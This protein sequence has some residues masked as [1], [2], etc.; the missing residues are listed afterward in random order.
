GDAKQFENLRA[1]GAACTRPGTNTDPQSAQIVKRFDREALERREL[2]RAV[3]HRKYDAHRA[4]SGSLRPIAPVPALQGDAHGDAAEHSFFLLLEPDFLAP[5]LAHL[6]GCFDLQSSA[7]TPSQ[8]LAIGVVDPTRRRS[9]NGDG[10][11]PIRRLSPS[12]SARTRYQNHERR[13]Q[14]QYADHVC[15]SLTP[16]D[17]REGNRLSHGDGHFVGATG[18]H[19]NAFIDRARWFNWS[20]RVPWPGP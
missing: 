1:I 15:D 17:D 13:S 20:P 7:Q 3:V 5:P 8:T 10:A 18:R 2:K 19:S 11:G 14:V 12:R 4:I 16:A 9:P 6:A